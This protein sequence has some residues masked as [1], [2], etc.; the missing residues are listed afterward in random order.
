MI[1]RDRELESGGR[2]LKSIADGSAC[3]VLEGEAGIGKTTIWRELMGSAQAS[4]YR[5]LSCRP[6]ATEVTLSFAGLGDLLSGVEARLL[7]DL[8][9]P[10]RHALEVALLETA[11]GPGPLEQRA[12]FAGLSSVLRALAAE[13][14]LL[15]A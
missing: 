7:S 2:F 9:S 4:G 5:V 12:V 11:P 3:L 6:A 13:R 15:V 1:G 14:P 8:P 10:Q